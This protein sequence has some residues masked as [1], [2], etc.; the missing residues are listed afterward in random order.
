MPKQLGHVN[1][2]AYAATT[3]FI[4]DPWFGLGVYAA[5]SPAR[6]L[7]TYGLPSMDQT[8]TTFDLILCTACF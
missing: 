2:V 6:V 1:G 7:L 8:S 5:C 3:L 4:G